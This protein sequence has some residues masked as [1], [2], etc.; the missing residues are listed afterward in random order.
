MI[1]T[2]GQ[3]NALQTIGSAPASTARIDHPAAGDF[4]AALTGAVLDVAGRLRQAEAVSISGVKGEASQ[5]EVVS[6]VMN[7]EQ[8]LQAAIA[9]RDKVVQAYLE[10]SR[11]Q[12]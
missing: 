3:V 1:D 5:L 8:Q 12:I 2:V 10:I 9:I 7:A 4:E 6:T 11:M